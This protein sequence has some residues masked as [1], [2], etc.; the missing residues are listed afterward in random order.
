MR[1]APA[2]GELHRRLDVAVL[3][4]V[5]IE[6]RRLRGDADVL[7]EGGDD[8]L[9][10]ELLH[11]FSGGTYPEAESAPPPKKW[12]SVCSMRYLRAFGSARL[13]RFSLTSMVCCLS[14]CAQASLE[15][16]S[17]MRL[18][19][20]P[21]KGGKSRPSASRPSFTHFTVRAMPKIIDV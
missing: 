16:F 5:A 20:S 17:Q 3:L 15:T 11:C 2:R 12:R 10:P 21:G 18:P 9:V 4:P 14:H 8:G 6:M 19:R 13:R 7:D 1:L